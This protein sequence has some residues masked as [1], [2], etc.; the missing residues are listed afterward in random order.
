VSNCRNQKR[1]KGITKLGERGPESE[2]VGHK[3]YELEKEIWRYFTRMVVEE[4]Y[5]GRKEGD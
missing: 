3:Y 2:I 4:K 5:R 1:L